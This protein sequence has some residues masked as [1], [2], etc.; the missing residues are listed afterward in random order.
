MVIENYWDQE[1]EWKT[2]SE[3][4]AAADSSFALYILHLTCQKSSQLYF[5]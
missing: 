2:R 5:A 4:F 1:D 3:S